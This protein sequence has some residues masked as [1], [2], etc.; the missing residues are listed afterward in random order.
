MYF[1]GNGDQET[2]FSGTVMPQTRQWS[3]FHANAEKKNLESKLYVCLVLTFCSEIGIVYLGMAGT[4]AVCV[5]I[6]FLIVS[7]YYCAELYGKDQEIAMLNNSNP[8]L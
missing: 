3:L 6:L 1:G 8:G 5:P 7:I 4:A 2:V